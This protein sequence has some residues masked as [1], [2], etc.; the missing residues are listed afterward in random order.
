[1]T[2]I[3]FTDLDGTIVHKN[4]ISLQTK[5]AVSYL[6]GNDIKFSIATGRH[7][8]A[9]MKFVNELEITDP[10]ICGNGAYI[11]NPVTKEILSVSY[12]DSKAA[13]Q[14][15]DVAF[16]LKVDF[17]LYTKDFI[18]GT[19]QPIEKVRKN[20]GSS[21]EVKE[22]ADGE[23]EKLPL[24]EIFKILIMEDDED[25]MQNVISS[26]I[27]IEHVQTVQSRRDFLDVGAIGI[28]KGAAIQKVCELLGIPIE[29]SV[30]FGDEDNDLEMLRTAGVG[31]AM[32]N[33]TLAAK[34]SANIVTLSVE[35]DGFSEYIKQYITL[36]K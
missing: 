23:M 34:K 18:Y 36:K 5:D 24:N 15:L 4:N 29:S 28:N 27:G 12:M 9:V 10:V 35:E 2:K 30:A 8:T 32:K 11:F 7:H 14:V 22:V 6:K 1:M 25:I 16:L 26:L 19:K 3:V 13:E 31:V 20:M 33:G 17:L 21:V